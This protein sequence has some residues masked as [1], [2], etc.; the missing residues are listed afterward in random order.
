MYDETREFGLQYDTHIYRPRGYCLL[1]ERST[2]P[3]SQ[4]DMLAGALSAW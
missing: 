2:H 4:I 1:A 3:N